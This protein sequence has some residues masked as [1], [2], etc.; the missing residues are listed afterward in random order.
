VQLYELPSVPASLLG[1]VGRLL[2]ARAE[3]APAA[4]VLDALGELPALR[5]LVR[6]LAPS[7][8]LAPS[9]PQARLPFEITWP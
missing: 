4:G 2:G 9:D 3:A 7:I 8:L 1:W 5:E 6:G